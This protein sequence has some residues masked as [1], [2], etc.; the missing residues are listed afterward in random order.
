MEISTNCL[1]NATDFLEGLVLVRQIQR[2]LAK[3][4]YVR[5][6]TVQQGLA[7]LPSS[8]D[9]W[10]VLC[11][12]EEEIWVSFHNLLGLWNKQL[13]VVIQHLVDTLECFS[14]YVLKIGGG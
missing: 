6:Y 3:L 1:T 12:K 2:C 8:I 5:M 13:T 11:S 7:N 14:D 4:C 9:A 10:R